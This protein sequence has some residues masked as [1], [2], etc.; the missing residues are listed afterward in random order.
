LVSYDGSNL[1]VYVDGKRAPRKYELT[2]GAPL[3]QII[4]HINAIELE[5]YTY[6]YYALVFVPGGFLLGIVTRR[7]TQ[8]GVREALV[9]ALAIVM[10]SILLEMLLVR[11]SGRPFSLFNVFLSILFLIAGVIW[12][13]ADRRLPQAARMTN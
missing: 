10:P 8:P 13:N 12:I 7:L 4:R 9:M 1:S 6:I 11:I 3:A 2:P 5:G